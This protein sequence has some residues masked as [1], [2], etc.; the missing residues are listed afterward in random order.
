MP[1]I[2]CR[3]LSLPDGAA[4]HDFFGR[5]LNS[6]LNA[7]NTAAPTMVSPANTLSMIKSHVGIGFSF[8]GSQ[9]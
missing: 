4:I 5:E 6:G 9:N 1:A 3:S 8:R 2:G 7:R